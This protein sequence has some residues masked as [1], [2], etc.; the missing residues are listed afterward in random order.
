MCA[1]S[2]APRNSSALTND[3]LAVGVETLGECRD[4]G[5]GLASLSARRA[6]VSCSGDP[7]AAGACML[8][9]EHLIPGLA[10]RLVTKFSTME[11][12]LLESEGCLGRIMRPTEAACSRVLLYLWMNSWNTDASGGRRLRNKNVRIVF[13]NL[14]NHNW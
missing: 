12:S 3:V 9:L 10:R 7:A 2:S 5:V 11:D 13:D 14:Y 1:L 6:E 8:L 4:W